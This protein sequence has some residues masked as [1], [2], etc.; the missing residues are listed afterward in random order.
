M[1]RVNRELFKIHN[2][3]CLQMVEAFEWEEYKYELLINIF[4]VYYY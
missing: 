2:L 1:S 3:K 4:C